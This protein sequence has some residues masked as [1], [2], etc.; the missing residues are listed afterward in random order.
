MK[1]SMVKSLC[2]RARLCGSA[3]RRAAQREDGG[4]VALTLFLL[5]PM[6]IIGGMAVDFMRFEARRAALQGVTD[7]AVLAAANLRQS[8]DAKSVVIDYFTK[9]GMAD[10]LIGEPIV[11]PGYKRRE[12]QA[13]SR[14][15]VE[16]FFLNL[17][18]MDTLA[19]T[20][21]SN[22]VQGVGAV[23]VSLVLDLSGSMYTVIKNTNPKV[24]RIEKLR[25][26]ATNF[27]TA[28]LKPEYANRISV[29]LVPYSE[30]VN[31]GPE[32]FKRLNTNKTHDFS[33]CLEMPD[34][35][36][37]KTAF[38]LGRT[39]DQTQNIQTNA[40]GF[41][42]SDSNSGPYLRDANDPSLD[43]PVCPKESYEQIVPVS[44]NLTELTTNIG[45]FEPRAGTSIFLGLKWGITLLDPSFDTIIGDLPASMI[46]DAF[47]DRPAP[48][49]PDK[50]KGETLRS[51]KYLVL[52]TDGYNDRSWR[53]KPEFYDDPS[54]RNYWAHNTWNYAV[55]NSNSPLGA[56]YYGI[57]T[58][59]YLE[60]WFTVA[61]GN[62]YM[63]SMCNAAK[64]A[65]III[66]A[67][68]MS[69]DD[70]S[71]DAVTGRTQMSNCATTPN[72]FFATSGQELDE[73]FERIAKQITDLRLT[74]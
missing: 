13:N 51:L 1:R 69:G 68:S 46:D 66:Y 40:H 32:L 29:S 25:S 21:T 43:Q 30:Q 20:A 15:S 65:G 33:Y 24:R 2:E 62:G 53:I 31:I 54:E 10:Q 52:M 73:I 56:P 18:G 7:R 8:Q 59:D 42:V 45:K 39:Y 72:H 22:A 58:Y 11:I 12:V 34:A 28:L 6:L 47:S 61:Q 48:Y 71:A 55:T 50:T 64:D 23:E 60:Q 44:Q 3:L 74:L 35:G 38:D 19:T 9:N 67:I 27:V 16:T 49:E 63:E 14:I 5:I 4:I 41:G 17:I 26:A 36:F 37:T 70:D 57:G